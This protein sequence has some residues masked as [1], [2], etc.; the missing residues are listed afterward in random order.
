MPIYKNGLSVS[1]ILKGG[2]TINSFWLNNTGGSS[3]SLASI[4]KAGDIGQLL[5]PQ[6][7]GSAYADELGTT[8]ITSGAVG[9]ILDQSLGIKTLSGWL[10]L[11]LTPDYWI[12]DAAGDDSNAGTSEGA[13][14]ASLNKIEGI[15]GTVNT[16]TIVRV[17]TGTYD[18]LADH[19]V[20]NGFV[21]RLVV[22][23]EPGCIMDGT[24]NGTTAQNPIYAGNNATVMLIYGN[25]LSVQNFFGLTGG[26]PNGLGYGGTGTILT[27]Y[28]VDISNCSD[29]ISGHGAGHG[30]FYRVN[31]AGDNNKTTVANVDSST[32]NAYFCSFLANNSTSGG[33]MI[34]S[35]GLQYF[36]DCVLD[37]TGVTAVS[38]AT[39]QGENLHF[40]RCQ[41]GTTS[42]HMAVSGRAVVAPETQILIED[43]Y[44]N[45]N[46]QALPRTTIRRSY[47]KL[48]ARN[49]SFAGLSFTVENCVLSGPAS[50]LGSIVFSDFNPGGGI[51]WVFLNNIV[52]TAT[53]GAFM[54]ID[55]T[56]AGYIVAQASEFF[57]NILS[58][59]AAFDADLIAAD[60]GGTVIVGNVTADALIGAA[61]TLAPADYGYTAGSPA[62][63][64][65]TDGGNCGFSVADAAE[66]ALVPAAVIGIDGIPGY[67][68]KQ[69]TAAD[70]PTLSASEVTFGAGDSLATTFPDL[71]TDVTI[72]YADPGVGAV[73]LT[74][75]TVGA[76]AYSGY[77]DNNGWLMIDRALTAAETALATKEL[78]K[79]A[80]V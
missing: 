69:A 42:A 31:V 63:G 48:S 5:L 58:G 80:G 50:G 29:G 22:V 70:R 24:A 41:L 37:P 43:C 12:D 68:A 28:D 17:K 26:T 32:M 53:A 64:A 38:R 7:V 20:I 47:G 23:F 54:A 45:I 40:V 35:A 1:S 3:P 8:S 16:D 62:I 56:N 14:W 10:G 18:K 52:E 13:A 57:N 77:V 39:V 65:A 25:G 66:I 19:F 9:L 11:D 33:F 51:K 15:S 36:E 60:T 61:N 72:A 67:H 49:R 75:Q 30:V 59:S 73:F 2:E 27:A 55:A 34:N 46:N 78:D 76:G 71:G 74:A 4:F 79:L 21:G 44:I 6:R